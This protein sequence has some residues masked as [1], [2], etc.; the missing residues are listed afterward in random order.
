M[1]D[2]A[3]GDQSD[4]NRKNYFGVVGY[5]DSILRIDLFLRIVYNTSIDVITFLG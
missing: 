1:A 2:S 4:R 5:S 3:S